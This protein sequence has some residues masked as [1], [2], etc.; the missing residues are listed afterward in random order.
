MNP[1]VVMRSAYG[2]AAFVLLLGVMLFLT[3]D[4]TVFL[5]FAVVGAL[6]G[7]AG[8]LSTRGSSTGTG[9]DVE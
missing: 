2:L 6:T 8:Y 9:S 5:S 4:Q 3:T 1:A 7:L